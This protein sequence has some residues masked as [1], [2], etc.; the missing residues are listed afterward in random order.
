M[1]SHPSF[2]AQDML[3]CQAYDASVKAWVNQ[4]GGF[5]GDPPAGYDHFRQ[6]HPT[7]ALVSDFP[8]VLR[9]YH[10]HMSGINASSGV[11][12]GEVRLPPGAF[13][14]LLGMPIKIM[15]E[16]NAN[17]PKAYHKGAAFGSP[18][19]FGGQLMAHHQVGGLMGRSGGPKIKGWQRNRG[20]KVTG[21]TRR[22][23]RNGGGGHGKKAV[24]GTGGAKGDKVVA[25]REREE[26][27]L[28]LDLEDMTL[29]EEDVHMGE[30]KGY[31]G[32]D[33]DDGAAGAAV[34]WP[35][36]EPIAPA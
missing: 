25:K 24:G 13:N 3:N 33:E 17:K 2:S 7:A 18:A 34:A 32:D 6:I 19:R 8:R 4:A 27:P 21:K 20:R 23:N 16:L 28:P 31:E 29:V 11:P 26:T 5:P 9:E 35:E 12:G 36:E 14:A 1:S 10:R 15:Q 22:N 30:Y